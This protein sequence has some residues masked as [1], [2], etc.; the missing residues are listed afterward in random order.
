MAADGAARRVPIAGALRPLAGALVRV[1]ASPKPPYLALRIVWIC[2]VPVFVALYHD[3]TRHYLWLPD[4]DIVIVYEA[5]LVNDGLPNVTAGHA[6][7][8]HFVLLARLFEFLKLL[9]VVDAAA[10]SELPPPPAS[11]IVFQDLVFWGRIV[12]VAFTCALA[13]TILFV[14]QAIT[15]SR[16]YAFL[17]AL[18]FAGTQ[19]LNTQVILMRSDLSAVVFATLAIYFILLA[20][21]RGD[22]PMKALAYVGLSAF[23]A[24][25]SMYAK[26]STL[27]LVL[28]VPAFAVAFVAR[29]SGRRVPGPPTRLTGGLVVLA[30]LVG[31][32]A[33]P[34]LFGAMESRAILYNGLIAAYVVACIVV[35]RRLSGSGLE[36]AIAG[37]AAVVLGLGLAHPLMHR[38]GESRKMAIR[39]SLTQSERPRCKQ[40]VAQHCSNLNRTAQG[41]GRVRWRNHPSDAGGLL[42]GRLDRGLGLIRRMASCFTDRRDPHDLAYGRRWSAS[43]FGCSRVGYEDLNEHDELR[44]PGSLWLAFIARGQ[45]VGLCTGGRSTARSTGCTPRR[46]AGKLLTMRR[47]WKHSSWTSSSMA[48]IERRRRRA[49]RRHRRH[50]PRRARRSVL[51]WLLR[52]LL[53]PGSTSSA[54][55]SC[56]ASSCAPPSCC[57]GPTARS[58]RSPAIVC[59]ASAPAGRWRGSCCAAIR[60]LLRARGDGVVRGRAC[61]LSSLA[62]NAP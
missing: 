6:G 33:L 39:Q 15:G 32:L 23:L 8:G 50:D 53:L 61:R 47:A 1:F 20:T 9:G 7:F 52:Q 10:L 48:T 40:S 16:F 4:W 22:A 43:A 21:K 35:Y 26:A 28:L 37:A 12:A 54:A 56:S 44:D 38:G 29:N 34:E 19:S 13:V 49:R 58:T 5:L 41:C 55:G 42:L 17:A 30:L 51:P 25:I 31:G 45:A 11:E 3:I 2:A 14:A 57:T 18:A 60:P 36:A 27:P 59:L 46:E 24:M 62:S